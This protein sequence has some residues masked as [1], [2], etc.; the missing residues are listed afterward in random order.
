MR[1][2]NIFDIDDTIFKVENLTVFVRDKTTDEVRLRLIGGPA[3]YTHKLKDN[4]Y[5]DFSEFRCGKLFRQ[6]ATPIDK[7]ID[8]LLKIFYENADDHTIFLTARS[9]LNDKTAYLQ[10]FK[11]HKIPIDYIYIERAGNLSVNKPQYRSHIT[12]A[13]IVKKYLSTKLYN[14]VRM[15]DDHLNNLKTFLKLQKFFPE[16]EFEAYLVD[17][18]TGEDILL[19]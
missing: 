18:N 2:L 5:F 9:D 4:E 19:A 1:T 8:K 13:F 3:F 16:I 12:K 7:M 17:S 11:D 10:K 15:W 14:K 6:T